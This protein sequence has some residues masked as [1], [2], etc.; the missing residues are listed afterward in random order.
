[1]DSIGAE[2]SVCEGVVCLAIQWAENALAN[3]DGAFALPG[4]KV[5]KRKSSSIQCIVAD[6]TESP[7]NRPKEGQK[8]YYSGENAIRQRPRP[9]LGEPA[10]KSLTYKPRAARV[11][12]RYIKKQ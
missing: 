9:S 8:A 4:K 2:Y 6:V 3:K 1:M 10:R 12:S 7:A 5:L 11:A